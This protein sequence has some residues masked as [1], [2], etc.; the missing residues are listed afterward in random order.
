DA[1]ALEI[2]ALEADER[3][4]SAELAA[5]A[6]RA[7]IARTQAETAPDDQPLRTAAASV[8]AC[9]HALQS[10]RARLAEVQATASR[11]RMA[12][13][14]GHGSYAQS[15]SD[16]GLGSWL[17]DLVGLDDA[18]SSYGAEIGAIG[19]TFSQYQAATRRHADSERVAQEAEVE[20]AAAARLLIGL[21]G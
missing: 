13:D 14:T 4:I 16:L 15:A 9:G 8:E 12:R 10:L 21:R 1:L 7:E 6:H 19:P 5:L 20:A 2:A 18:V 3:Q 11:A 17:P